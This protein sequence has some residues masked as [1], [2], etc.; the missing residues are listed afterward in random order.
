MEFGTRVESSSILEREPSL[1]FDV[2]EL[3]QEE[4]PQLWRIDKE[5]RQDVHLTP[6]EARLLVFLAQRPRRWVT[7]EALADDVWNDSEMGASPIQAAVSRLRKKLLGFEHLI[8][9]G[10]SKYR[11]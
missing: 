1:V 2:F 9:S 10:A 3:L 6:L 8:E 7:V 4:P 11:L 5:S